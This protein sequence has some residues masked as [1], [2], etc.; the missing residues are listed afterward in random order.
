MRRL[1]PG[2]RE[3]VKRIFVVVLT[4]KEDRAICGLNR[5]AVL[6]G[7]TTALN[8][9]WERRGEW[10]RLTQA[11]KRPHEH[12]SLQLRR[13]PHGAFSARR[14]ARDGGSRAHERVGADPPGA[15]RLPGRRSTVSHDTVDQR[16]HSRRRARWQGELVGI[17]T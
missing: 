4:V 11:V 12:E 1:Y 17:L 9:L 7:S 3:E 16:S 5:Q 14:S 6:P 15:P 2:R 8:C 10:L 13:R